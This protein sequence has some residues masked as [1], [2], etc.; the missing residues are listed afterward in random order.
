MKKTGKIFSLIL[1][2]VCLLSLIACEKNVDK[3]VITV[4]GSEYDIAGKTLEEYMSMISE[5]ENID[6]EVGNGMMLSIN[7]TTN[8]T[9]SFWMLYTD[10]E[11]N[12]NTAW[13]TIEYDGK[14]YASS[15]LGLTELIV[16]DGATYIWVY[17]TF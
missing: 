15:S 5:K 2:I 4:S 8:T 3:V 16:K 13:G 6:Y 10:D 1:I 12:S 9:K 14:T 7:G 11:D 17:Q